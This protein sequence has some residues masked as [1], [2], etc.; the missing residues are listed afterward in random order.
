MV[1]LLPVPN[2]AADRYLFRI[3]DAP[4]RALS[5]PRPDTVAFGN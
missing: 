3:N 2:W 4:R 1:R 5:K